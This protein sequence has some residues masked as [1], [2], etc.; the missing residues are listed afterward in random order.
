MAARTSQEEQKRRRRKRLI[1]G[2]LLG[3]AA[4]GLPA[5]ANALIARRSPRLETPRWG[6][7]RRYA[8]KQ[9]ECAFQVLGEGP[10]LLLLHSFG[11]GHD[12]D[13]WSQ[14]GEYLAANHEVF[15]PDLLGWG[16]SDRPRLNYDSE[17]YIQLISDFLED[18]VQ[19]PSTIVAAGLSAAYAVQV[20]VD[21]PELVRSLA[22]VVPSGIEVH[23]DEPDLKDALVHRLLRLPVLGTSALNLYTSRTALGQ[24]LRRDVIRTPEQVDAARV[25]HHYRS[26]HQAGSHAPLAAYLTGYLNHRVDEILARLDLPLWLAWGRHATTPPIETADFWLK[27]LPDTELEVFEETGNLPHLE[28]PGRFCRRLERHLSTLPE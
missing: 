16:R 22:A 8:W 26:S 11:P 20:A 24:Y 5:L 4:V 28:A 14:A 19:Q 3:G 6:R 10:P 1:K 7:Y 27:Q 17:L 2:L 21:R 18:I 13:E 15:V 23:G 12:S 25:E 9:G